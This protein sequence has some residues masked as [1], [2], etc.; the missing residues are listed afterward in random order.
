MPHAIK[1]PPHI[2]PKKI[3][4]GASF[5]TST[6]IEISAIHHRFMPPATKSRPIKIQQ[7][8]AQYAPCLIPMS[9]APRRPSRQSAVKKLRG[10]RQCLRQTCLSG[11]HWKIPAATSKIPPSTGL[12][13]TINGDNSAAPCKIHCAAAASKLKPV[14][15][16]M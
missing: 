14:Q 2:C 5:S 9:H 16:V 1:S 3:P 13:L 4:R 15:I 7:H 8:P 11:V 12:V 6:K 10:E